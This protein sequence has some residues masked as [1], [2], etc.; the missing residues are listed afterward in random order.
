MYVGNENAFLLKELRNAAYIEQQNR[1]LRVQMETFKS[2]FTQ[3]ILVCASYLFACHS[4]IYR[5]IK[6][7]CT[8]SSRQSNE[9]LN[10]I[11]HNLINPPPP[12]LPASPPLLIIALI[13]TTSSRRPSTPY[14]LQKGYYNQATITTVTA[15]PV[16]VVEVMIRLIIHP[17]EVRASSSPSRPY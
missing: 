4:Y 9:T 6:P 11:T 8:R 17:V 3:C 13:A 12:P 14:A 2:V 16:A 15:A 7:S 1:A 5:N 10:C